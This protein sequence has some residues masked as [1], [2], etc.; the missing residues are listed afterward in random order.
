MLRSG[1]IGFQIDYSFVIKNNGLSKGF[2]TV[3]RYL[4]IHNP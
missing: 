3:H 2:V 4:F 1:G